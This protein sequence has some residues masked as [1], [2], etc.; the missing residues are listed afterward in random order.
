MKNAKISSSNNKNNNH[1]YFNSNLTN[2]SLSKINNDCNDT[3]KLSEN[4]FKDSLEPSLDESKTNF[5]LP[6]S[7]NNTNSSFQGLTKNKV[8]FKDKSSKNK[9]IMKNDVKQDFSLKTR[10][11]LEY[12][13]K[14]DPECDLLS[15]GKEMNSLEEETKRIDYRYYTNY[16]ISAF[17]PLKNNKENSDK[18]LFW[19]ATY[20]IN[21]MKKKNLIKILNYYNSSSEKS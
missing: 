17:L 21:L 9:E 15:Q 19:L 1:T 13:D 7:L 14:I 8:V 12:N 5:Y 2:D 11:T 10:N 4:A 3:S 16:P 18:S 20:D 6:D